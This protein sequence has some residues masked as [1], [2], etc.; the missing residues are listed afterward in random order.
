MNAFF[1]GLDTET[2]LLVGIGAA[3]AAGCIPCL[4]KMVKSANGVHLDPK[5]LKAAAI[6]GQFVKDQP[7]AHMKSAADDLLGTHL[8]IAEPKSICPLETSETQEQGCGCETGNE[9][10]ACGG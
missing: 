9:P 8:Q 7:A 6:I 5:K 4:E 3:V 10:C 2:Q 1:K